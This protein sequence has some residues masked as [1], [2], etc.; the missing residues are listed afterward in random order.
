MLL[1]AIVHREASLHGM[2]FIPSLD[3]HR[4]QRHRRA[5]TNVVEG[6]LL[7]AGQ[8]IMKASID[9]GAMGIDDIHSRVR[10]QLESLQLHRQ[11]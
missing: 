7:N 5:M 10:R 11:G 3:L 4:G 9:E 1:G 8:N 2:E 6:D